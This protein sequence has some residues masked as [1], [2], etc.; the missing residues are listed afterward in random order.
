MANRV[1]VKNQFFFFLLLSLQL[2]SQML[3][4][5]SEAKL[6]VIDVIDEWL[7]S[8][9]CCL[10]KFEEKKNQHNIID[11]ETKIA[12]R[13]RCM[14]RDLLERKISVKSKYYQVFHFFLFSLSL[15]LSLVLVDQLCVILFQENG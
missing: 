11:D 2:V 10:I 9:I 5:I 3:R 8:N 4:L 1:E 7:F 15:S 13:I 12:D 14:C 6:I